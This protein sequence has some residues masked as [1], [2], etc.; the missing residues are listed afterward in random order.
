MSDI[1]DFLLTHWGLTACAALSL[2][3]YI[4]SELKHR[5]G[6]KAVSTQKAVTLINDKN[7]FVLDVRSVK[8]LEQAEKRSIKNATHVPLGSLLEMLNEFKKHT[9][10]PA[11]VVCATGNRAH[12][13]WSILKAAG[14]NELYT[15]EGGMQSWQNESLPT[16]SI[17]VYN[18]K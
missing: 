12:A 15:L 13:A 10:R 7:A 3:G 6:L 8:E 5:S 18:T 11:L 9:Q 4:F 1:L 2:I 17:K 16:A 14:F